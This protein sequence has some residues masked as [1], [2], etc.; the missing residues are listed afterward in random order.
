MR[1]MLEAIIF[2]MATFFLSSCAHDIIEFDPYAKYYDHLFHVADAYSICQSE[3]CQN[4]IIPIETE[5]TVPN[6]PPRPC[7]LC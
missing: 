3:T 4:N 6:L 2:I 5:G 7:W 1:T